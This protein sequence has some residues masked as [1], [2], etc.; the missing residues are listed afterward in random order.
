MQAKNLTPLLHPHKNMQN[1]YLP[2]QAWALYCLVL[3]WSSEAG[4][5]DV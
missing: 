5:V 1:I 2:T 3:G 4:E